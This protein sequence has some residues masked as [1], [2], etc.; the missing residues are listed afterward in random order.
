M[1]ESRQLELAPITVPVEE[2]RVV[3]ERARSR[4]RLVGGVLAMMLT[5]VAGRGVQLALDPD[6]RTLSI[7]AENRWAAVSTQGPRGDILDASGNV[8]AM[9]V[10]AP[11]VFAD[12]YAMHDRGLDMQQIIS[13]LAEVLEVPAA[14]LAR[15]LSGQARYVRLSTGI[16]P[17]SAAEL[18]RRGL[19]RAR[20]IIVEEN[21]RRYYPQGTLAAQVL[22]FVDE[23]G[24]GITGLERAYDEQLSGSSFVYQQR[25]NRFGSVVEDWQNDE[26]ASQGMRLQT[27][28]DRVV[29]RSTERALARAVEQFEPVSATA[30]VIEV[31][32]GRVLAMASMPTFNPNR[33]EEGDLDYTRNLAMSDAIEP[34]SVLKPVTLAAALETGVTH[35]D[36][37][38]DTTSPYFIGGARI[39]DDHAHARTRVPDMIKHSSNIAAAKLAQRVGAERFDAYLKLFGFGEVSGIPTYGEAAGVRHPRHFGPVEL[40]TISYGQG[41]TATALQVASAMATIANDGVRMRPLIVERIVDSTGRTIR[42]WEPSV[43]ARVVSA[44]TARVVAQAMATVFDEGGTA[45]TLSLPGYRPAGKTGTAYKVKDGRYSAT[46]RYASFAGFAPVD[47]P[48]VAVVVIV[49]EPTR[50]SRYGGTVAGP[51]F[52]DVMA[53][54][55][56]HRGVPMDPALL[57]PPEQ[58][59]EPEE[60]LAVYTPIQLVWEGASWRLPDL[61]G[62]SLREVL[63]GLQGAGLQLKLEGS[64]TLASQSPPA[65]SPVQPGDVVQLRFR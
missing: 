3:R 1:R 63:A 29:Q 12:A 47:D 20:G 2:R 51:V 56:A 55:L 23:R 15:K 30:V 14:D 59:G 9:S 43:A 35:L 40:A 11:A 39:R 48:D 4:V 21:Y 45:A 57:D 65:G 33:L 46:A 28:I 7:A 53:E 19:T 41:L 6:E 60:P 26:R 44:D 49:D 32:T 18:R 64:G 58:E 34:G 25:V 8:L 62:R 31:S 5:A 52:I 13:G 38:L 24:G 50:G 54:T 37:V 10:R 17:E 36:E 42:A 16:T 27:T 61:H 22:G